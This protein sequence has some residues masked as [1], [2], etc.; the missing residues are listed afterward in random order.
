M[1]THMGHDAAATVIAGTGAAW[2]MNRVTTAFYERQSPESKRRERE[3]SSDVAYAVV[4][5]KAASLVGKSLER[6]SAERLGLGFH[7]AVGVALVPGYV[8]LRRV[9]GLRPLAAGLALGLSASVL[10]DEVANPVLGSSAPPTDYPLV[11]H[12]RGLAG[13]VAFGLAVPVLFE[14]T[15]AVLRRRKRSL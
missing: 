9:I 6:D 8:V 12:L 15:V 2:A 13:H 5:Q 3:A 1:R 11:T 7:Y 10:V 4:V 14:S